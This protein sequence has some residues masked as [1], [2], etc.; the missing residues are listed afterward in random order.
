MPPIQG[1]EC[2]RKAARFK[3]LI[4]CALR[5]RLKRHFGESWGWA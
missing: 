3:L 5:L 4:L 2:R 1:P